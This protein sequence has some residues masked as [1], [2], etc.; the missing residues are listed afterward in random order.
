LV[1]AM[2]YHYMKRELNGFFIRKEDKTHGKKQR[3]VGSVQPGDQCLLIEDVITTGETTMNSV[4]LLE[5]F[6]ADV[7]AVVAVVNR[8]ASIDLPLYALTSLKDFG[9]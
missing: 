5:D 9:L 1:G 3:I 2:L 8:G 7:V 6:G 4:K